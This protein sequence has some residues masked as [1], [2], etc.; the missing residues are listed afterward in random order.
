MID[1]K[2]ACVA[3]QTAET[4]PAVISAVRGYLSS[5]DASKVGLLPPTILTIGIDHAREL[6]Q[7]S[8][9]L[10]ERELSA[11]LDD[12]TSAFLQEAATVFSTAS[13]RLAVPAGRARITTAYGNVSRFSFVARR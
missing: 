12:S 1:G 5:L 10:A 9:E 3:I 13:M 8:V 6:A 7:A 2:A 11:A 4:Q